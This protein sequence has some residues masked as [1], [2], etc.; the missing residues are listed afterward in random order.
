LLLAPDSSVNPAAS[1]ICAGAALQRIAGTP[2]D[3]LTIVAAPKK[4]YKMLLVINK[5]VLK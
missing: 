4:K 2:A 1:G 5:G 3:L